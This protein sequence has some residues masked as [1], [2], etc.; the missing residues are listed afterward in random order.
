VIP[1]GGRMRRV[2]VVGVSLAFVA[3]HRVC[4]DPTTPQISPIHL[5]R[6]D[7]QRLRDQQRGLDGEPPA[8]PAPGAPVPGAPAPTAAGAPR[9]PP[10]VPEVHSGRGQ[11][12]GGIV[13]VGIAGVSALI[14]VP[15]LIA[16]S[17]PDDGD[18]SFK[19]VHDG[20]T[21]AGE[22]FLVTALV[23]GVIGISLIATSK[24]SVQLVPVA[25]PNSAGVAIRARL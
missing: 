8:A 18:P 10:P 25:T 15:L 9:K 17:G 24:S 16:G 12:T 21:T 20:W 6:E 3:P 7:A 23:T 13:L 19:S 14:S 5:Q 4:A 11:R 1:S 2:L 22:V